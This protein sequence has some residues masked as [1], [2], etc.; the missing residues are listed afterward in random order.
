MCMKLPLQCA[1]IGS[2]GPGSWRAMLSWALRALYEESGSG[3]VSPTD[4]IGLTI[5]VER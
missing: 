1:N 3:I 2:S 5:E 4:V